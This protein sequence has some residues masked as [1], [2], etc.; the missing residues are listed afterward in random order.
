MKSS[1]TWPGMCAD[2]V[3]QEDEGALEHGDEV[4]VVG[5]VA[6]DLRGQLGDALL[7]LRRQRVGFRTDA[8]RA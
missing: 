2:E 4:Q 6:A 8:A 1:E 5:E 7:N 3:G